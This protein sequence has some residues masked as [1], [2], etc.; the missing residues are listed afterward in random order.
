MRVEQSAGLFIKF[1]NLLKSFLKV[2]TPKLGVST[3]SIYNRLESTI[4]SLED[5]LNVPSG[6]SPGHGQLSSDGLKYYFSLEDI[7]IGSKKLFL[8]ERQNVLSQ[9]DSLYCLEN[10][11]FNT[12]LR[13]YQPSV[14]NQRS[15]F[16]R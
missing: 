5:T 4:Y 11:D 15:L 8:Y 16:K 13:Y 14:S 6:Y 10:D 7:L 9:C 12:D 1:L 3:I 2:E